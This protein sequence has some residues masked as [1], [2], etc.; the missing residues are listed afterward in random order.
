[1]ELKQLQTIK[2]ILQEGSFLKAAEK[3][4]Y[5]QSTITLHI[6]QLEEE[7]GIKLFAKKGRRMILSQ[8]GAF[9]WANAHLLI[10]RVDSLKEAMYEL[11]SG[12]TGH[13]RIGTIETIGKA[14][15]TPILINFYKR[16]PNMQLSLEFGGT[17]SISQRVASN[18]LDFGICPVPPASLNL[19]FEPL[20]TEHMDLLLPLDHP[21]AA[22]ENL[23]LSD[24]SSTSVVLSEPVCSYRT[25]IEHRF[26][27]AG[28]CLKSFIQISDI[29]TIV[30]FVRAGIGCAILPALA[31]NPTP[32]MTVKRS[33]VDTEFGLTIGII[34]KRERL[35]KISEKLYSHI[36]SN[37]KRL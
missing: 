4:G 31:I 36:M 23:V 22:K 11:T 14:M 33:L 16:H 13:V 7:M 6:H 29:N 5:A 12:Q 21:L 20:F 25:E 19:S 35:W 8:E 15:L 18:Q 1:M 37:L 2:S 28:I 32:P 26:V 17:E 24:L 10:E 3:L 27:E 9:F 30:E 34:R